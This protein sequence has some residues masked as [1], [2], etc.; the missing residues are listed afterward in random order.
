VRGIGVRV[1]GI[2]GARR[3]LQVPPGYAYAEGFEGRSKVPSADI[4]FVAS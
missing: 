3:R 2:G 1:A 4:D